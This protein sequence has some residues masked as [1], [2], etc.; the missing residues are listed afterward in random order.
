MVGKA[1]L[2][3]VMSVLGW[4]G[5]QAAEWPDTVL[6]RV[7][8]TAVVATLN[9]TLL[10][11]PSATV[12]LE[13]WCRDHHLAAEPKIVARAIPGV[14]KPLTASQRE[15]LAIGQDEPVRYRHVE[16]VCGERVLSVADNWYVGGRLTPEMNQLLETTQT[17]FGRAVA[18]LHFTR[19]T[20]EAT[21]LWSPLAPGWESSRQAPVYA[22]GLTPPSE[23]LRHRAVLSR[24]D[25]LPFSEVVETYTG[26]ML[27]FDPPVL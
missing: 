17:P 6:S 5:A 12:T 2:M 11:Q 24:G 15:E 1:G 20:I 27:A 19:R 7:E 13:T 18:A 25:G 3:G 26:E 23:I 4:S 16:L 14:D 10:S 21:Y 8:I 9:A 22:S